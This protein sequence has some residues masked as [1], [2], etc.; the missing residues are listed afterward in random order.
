MRKLLIACIAILM[1]CGSTTSLVAAQDKATP[2]A[3]DS[4]AAEESN[5]VDPKIG[6]T[7]TYYGED[8]SALGNVTITGIE[9]GWEDYDEYYEPD[10]GSEYVAFTVRVESTIER[11]AIDV[12]SYDFSLQTAGGYLWGG[13]YVSAEK[14]DPPM[15]EDTVSLAQGD[16][17][18]FTVVF[19]VI[20]DEPLAHIYWQPDSG[21][22]ITAAQLEGE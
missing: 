16:S 19:T 15:L 17:E 12:E 10:A 13:S 11:G 4:V 5:A 7:V 21:V 22:L 1:V 3:S 2:A 18:E 9:R 6:D 8:G 14:A 20:E